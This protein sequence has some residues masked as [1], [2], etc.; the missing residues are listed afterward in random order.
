LVERD[1]V[2]ESRDAAYAICSSV[3]FPAAE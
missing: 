1:K 3:R 2:T